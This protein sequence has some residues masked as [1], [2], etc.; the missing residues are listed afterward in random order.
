ML[1]APAMFGVPFPPGTPASV[2]ADF[3]TDLMSNTDP[4]GWWQR[5]LDRCVGHWSGDDAAVV[6]GVATG[7]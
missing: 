5:R 6:Q 1:M 7:G 2:S 3:G 4:L